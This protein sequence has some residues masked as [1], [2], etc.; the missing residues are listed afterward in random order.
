MIRL[1]LLVSVSLFTF[2]TFGQ[3]EQTLTHPEL[4]R[5]I[6]DALS[7]A[8]ALKKSY[9]NKDTAEARALIKKNE[10]LLEY[11][12]GLLASGGFFFIYAEWS[13]AT[14][15]E[16]HMDRDMASGIKKGFKGIGWVSLFTAIAGGGGSY[17]YSE[18]KI[19]PQIDEILATLRQLRNNVADHQIE[20][21]KVIGE[22]S[23]RRGTIADQR[24]LIEADTTLEGLKH[25]VDGVFD[26]YESGDTAH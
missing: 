19:E 25:D 3:G 20:I 6:D 8:E 24:P 26:L 15:N 13:L 5:R 9:Q 16:K 17:A 22:A 4:M 23:S 14:F 11:S 10:K 21:A 18:I 12:I 1:I 2:S 7:K